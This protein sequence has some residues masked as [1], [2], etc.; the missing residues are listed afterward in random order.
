MVAFRHICG[1][2][3]SLKLALKSFRSSE[4][5][6]G[7]RALMKEGGMSSGPG[8]PFVFILAMAFVSSGMVMGRQ[9]SWLPQL[10]SLS[11]CLA[12]LFTDL[13]SLVKCSLLT[14]E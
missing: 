3:A 8:A 7:P 2:D 10:S 11:I 5:A 12:S 4:R 14:L 6:V 1:M 9:E 13:S